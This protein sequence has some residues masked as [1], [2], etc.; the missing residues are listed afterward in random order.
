MCRCFADARRPVTIAAMLIAQSS[1]PSSRPQTTIR[2]VL[3]PGEVA[4]GSTVLY[5]KYIEPNHLISSLPHIHG[6]TLLTCVCTGIP[7]RTLFPNAGGGDG[8]VKLHSLLCFALLFA[9]MCVCTGLGCICTDLFFWGLGLS[10]CPPR[11]RLV[12]ILEPWR[13]IRGLHEAERMCYGG[14]L[15]PDLMIPSERVLARKKKAEFEGGEN[16]KVQHA[17]VAL[18]NYS[19]CRVDA[20]HYSLRLGSRKKLPLVAPLRTTSVS[21][22]VAWKVKRLVRCDAMRYMYSPSDDDDDDDDDE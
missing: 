11:E 16:E 9:W 8:K 18:C 17:C 5:R 22:S 14:S 3:S 1:V 15:T 19:T 21:K 4:A 12:I 10:D 13:S 6:R 2:Y 7:R 20:A